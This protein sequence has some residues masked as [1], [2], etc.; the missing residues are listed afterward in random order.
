M[1]ND[2]AA[3]DKGHQVWEVV[4]KLGRIVQ[5]CKGNCRKFIHDG[6]TSRYTLAMSFEWS[7]FEEILSKCLARCLSYHNRC[8]H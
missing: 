6:F 1:K 4:S 7:I 2:F 8:V 3:Q 5:D